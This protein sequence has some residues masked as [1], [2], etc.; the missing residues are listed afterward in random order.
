MGLLLLDAYL[1]DGSPKLL[2]ELFKTHAGGTLGAFARRWIS[3]G[4]PELRRQLLDYIGDGCDRPHH[5]LLVKTLFKEAEKRNDDELIAHFLVAFDRLLGRVV[6]KI[7]T[8]SAGT[9]ETE[10]QLVAPKGMT[11]GALPKKHKKKKDEAHF[12]RRTRAYLCRRAMRYVRLKG[13]A[14]P[15][16]FRRMALLALGLYR[17]E[18][19]DTPTKLLDAWGLLHL[20]FWGCDAIKRDA[21]GA[22]V[23]RGSSLADLKPAPI[24]E[25]AWLGCFEDVLGLTDAPSR[26]V[27]NFAIDWLQR[28]YE[29]QLRTMT[30][31]RLLTWICGADPELADFAARLLPR[32]DG[33]DS[34]PVSAWIEALATKSPDAQ[35]LVCELA[36]ARLRSD[37][38]TLEQTIALACARPYPVARLGLSWARARTIKT[39]EDLS[40]ATR[41]AKAENPR[42]LADAIAWLVEVLGASKHTTATHVRDLFDAP[43]VE[44]RRGAI[45]LCEAHP[46]FREE[47]SL[48]AALSESPWPDARSYL[49]RHLEAQASALLPDERRHLWAT[50]ILSVH[51]GARERRAAVLQ[52]ATRIA[53]KPSE[54][55]PLLP[56]LALALRSVR[57]ADRRTALAAV[58]RAA[59]ATPSLRSAL[60]SAIPEL[61]FQ[62]TAQV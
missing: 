28:H 9:Y 51:R 41:L 24:F 52:V 21:P 3:D 18:H 48:W 2:G 6:R 17:D 44:A 49:L 29:T 61:S 27:R 32:A 4:R 16:R 15:K 31:Q 23:R 35:A 11:N 26:T 10:V 43:T 45:N 1:D 14:D 47:P 25:E 57:P 36:Q 12:S 50:T 59:H 39:A 33:L 58:A 37:R 38:L 54:S 60:A 30:A 20:L 46:R 13:H 53:R 19:L 8:W 42:I 5:R 34:L 22:I 7:T 40:H 62:T 55:G 56:L